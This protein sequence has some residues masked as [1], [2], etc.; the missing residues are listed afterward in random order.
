MGENKNRDND[1]KKIEDAIGSKVKILTVGSLMGRCWTTPNYEVLIME[2][3]DEVVLKEL[4]NE[5]REEEEKEKLLHDYNVIKSKKADF[6]ISF[7]MDSDVPQI[8]WGT[9]I[10]LQNSKI[11]FILHRGHYIEFG[12]SIRFLSDEPV[13]T[14]VMRDDDIIRDYKY[15]KLKYEK[16][17]GKKMSFSDVMSHVISIQSSILRKEQKR[18]KKNVDPK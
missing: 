3:D 7:S 12:N 10:S 6:V 11:P 2:V 16:I 5:D 15:L 8:Y 18:K 17:S 1:I 9:L 14:F 4:K 13:L